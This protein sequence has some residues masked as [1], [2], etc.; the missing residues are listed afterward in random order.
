M[1]ASS[2]ASTFQSCIIVRGTVLTH[3]V[4]GSA[5]SLPTVMALS[6]VTPLLAPSPPTSMLRML[7]YWHMKT[8]LQALLQTVSRI[9]RR[10]KT[11]ADTGSPLQHLPRG[12]P[13]EYYEVTHSG[14][15]GH[16]EQAS[17]MMGCKPLA[18]HELLISSN[19]SPLF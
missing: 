1:S 6:T 7:C 2:L 5:R 11:V 18:P 19:N 17:D 4:G 13:S 14:V 15:F 16:H 12:I 3:E 8:R 10:S 9:A